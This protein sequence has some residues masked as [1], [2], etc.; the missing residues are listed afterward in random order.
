MSWS[1]VASLSVTL[2]MPVLKSLGKSEVFGA[3][4]T[5]PYTRSFRHMLGYNR[6]WDRRYTF[7]DPKVKS[8][9][10][11]DR[12]K[13]WNIVPGDQVRVKTEADRNIYEVLSINRLSNFVRLKVPSTVS[14][15]LPIITKTNLCLVRKGRWQEDSVLE[16]TTT[17]RSPRIPTERRKQRTRAVRLTCPTLVPILIFYSVF[18]TRLSTS[19]P[20]FNPLFKRWDWQ[21]FAVNTVPK[22]P[23]WTGD[24]RDRVTVPWPTPIPREVGDGTHFVYS[25]RHMLTHL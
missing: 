9:K 5:N 21:R 13:F 3:W 7:R 15:I 24:R 25:S 20:K 10:T 12:V 2:L 8:A 6:H 17:R 1:P 18:A 11:K 19:K 16:S 23:S 22:L 14:C 4:T